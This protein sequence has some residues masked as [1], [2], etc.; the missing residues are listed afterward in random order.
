MN[1][2]FNLRNLYPFE[3]LLYQFII[4]ATCLVRDRLPSLSL[5]VVLGQPDHALHGVVVRAVAGVIDQPDLQLLG[6]VPHFLCAMHR[7]PV[8]VEGHLPER[9]Q[10]S[11]SS[12]KLAEGLSI[13]GPFE[14]HRRLQASLGRDGSDGGYR[15][16]ME[17]RDVGLRVLPPRSPVLSQYRRPRGAELVAVHDPATILQ[18]LL[19]LLEGQPGLLVD[20]ILVDRVDALLD[21]DHLLLD[22]CMLICQSQMITGHTA[23]WELAMEIAA[24]L[25]Q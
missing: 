23:L 20:L 7:E 4:F 21:P 19:Q 17:G 25:L 24:P 22:P 15:L 3:C 8:H 5:D 18:G 12:E 9:D 16:L 13:H 2:C 10:L 1:E 11:Q 6:L 14:V